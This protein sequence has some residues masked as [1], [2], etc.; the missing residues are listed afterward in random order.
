VLSMNSRHRVLAGPF[1]NR[2]EARNAAKRLRID[3]DIDGVLIAPVR[4]DSEIR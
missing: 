4:K 2:G 1:E 3:L